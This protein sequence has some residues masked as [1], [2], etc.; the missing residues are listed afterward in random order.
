M[1][2]GRFPLIA[3]QIV[4]SVERSLPGGMAGADRKLLEEMFTKAG[5]RKVLW[6]NV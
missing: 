4:V 2:K 6:K 3:P 5:A 1:A